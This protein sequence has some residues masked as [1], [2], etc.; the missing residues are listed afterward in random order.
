M[1]EIFYKN[2]TI[3]INMEHLGNFSRKQ[4]EQLSE[5]W[6]PKQEAEHINNQGYFN[7][8]ESYTLDQ[9]PGVKVNLYQYDPDFAP[10]HTPEKDRNQPDQFVVQFEPTEKMSEKPIIFMQGFM[11]KAT[12][13]QTGLAELARTT[14]RTVI[15]WEE[16]IGVDLGSDVRYHGQD[17]VG[18]KEYARSNDGENLPNPQLSK[19]IGV[20]QL[21]DRLGIEHAD[22][23]A[24]SEGAVNAS[25]LGY[26]N[27]NRFDTMTLLNPAGMVNHDSMLK[28]VV[29]GIKEGAARKNSYGAY[30]T[31]ADYVAKTDMKLFIN[32]S[33]SERLK[34]LKENLAAMAGLSTFDIKPILA[35]LKEEG[36]DIRIVAS[37]HDQLFPAQ[38]YSD[39]SVEDLV[40]TFVVAENS[41]HTGLLM[42]LEQVRAY[43]APLL[44]ADTHTNNIDEY[45]TD[46]SGENYSIAA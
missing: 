20:N 36:K 44:M 32:G 17:R 37:D 6:L 3:S 2:V 40:N 28:F 1:P 27:G 10:D 18:E 5:S 41:D 34:L 8:E 46:N 12:D 45:P 42:S 19:I 25:V 35:I 43:I 29:S 24:H 16:H 33:I 39:S 7:Y 31:P 22:V 21:L 13:F 11:G 38:T 4:T 30:G 23:V 9:V 14:G 26:L 15:A